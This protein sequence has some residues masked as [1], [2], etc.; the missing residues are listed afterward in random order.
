MCWY[1]LV[2]RTMSDYLL[3]GVLESCSRNRCSFSFTVFQN[4]VGTHILPVHLSGT[5]VNH[6]HVKVAD[7]SPVS[8][9]LHHQCFSLSFIHLVKKPLDPRLIDMGTNDGPQDLMKLFQIN[10]RLC[11]VCCTSFAVQYC[12]KSISE[13][14]Q[15]LRA[16]FLCR[17]DT[18][19]F[20]T[21]KS[22]D[23]FK[24]VQASSFIDVW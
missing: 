8:F 12:G 23:L 15:V 5:A 6:L 13:M 18:V 10:S 21:A 1:N 9:I 20:I 2:V 19:C 4:Q 3:L 22:K 24:G 17:A 16:Q 14:L 11:S 7:I